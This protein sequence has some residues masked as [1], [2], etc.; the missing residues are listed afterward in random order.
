MI[1]S[2]AI[3]R[4]R[5]TEAILSGAITPEGLAL[6]FAEIAPISRAFA[7]MVLDQRFDLSEMAIAT[8]LMAK[9]WGKPLVLLPI[10]LAARFQESALLCRRDGPIRRPEDLVGKRVGVR[11]YSQTTGLWLRGVSGDATLLDALIA[12]LAPGGEIILAGF[13]SAPLS[14]AFPPAFMREARLRIAA[15]WRQADLDAVRLMIADG[16]LRLDGLVTHR[17]DYAAASE[18]YRTAFEDPACLKMV[19]DWRRCR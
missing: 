19:L 3:G 1:L 16:R 4:Y 9:A 10:A 7:P 2:A 15:E 6:R 5:H 17:R 8:F 13:Y 14:F 11:A 18:A 12:R